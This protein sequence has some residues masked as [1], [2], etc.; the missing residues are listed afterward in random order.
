MGGIPSVLGSKIKL[1]KAQE[2]KI[3]SVW[4]WLNVPWVEIDKGCIETNGID[5]P[6]LSTRG[7]ER[8]VSLYGLLPGT[9]PPRL[10]REKL[11]QL[12]QMEIQPC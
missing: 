8:M 3:A 4:C 7:Q 9:K 1:L 2:H 5:V 10:H 11:Q 12:W 6:T